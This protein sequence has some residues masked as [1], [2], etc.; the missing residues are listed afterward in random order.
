MAKKCRR[1]LETVFGFGLF[2]LF[3]LAEDA[4][5]GFPDVGVIPQRVI[6]LLIAVAERLVAVQTVVQT[7]QVQFVT[8]N[9]Q[10]RKSRA[11]L[12]RKNKTK[13]CKERNFL[14][15]HFQPKNNLKSAVKG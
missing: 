12:T 10:Y 11:V 2:G 7:L 1:C 13:L 9:H 5:M 3:G 8:R 6:P 14:K 4:G 15:Q